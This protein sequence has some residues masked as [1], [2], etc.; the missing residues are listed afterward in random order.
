MVRSREEEG[1]SEFL[2]FGLVCEVWDLRCLL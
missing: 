1:M 2:D